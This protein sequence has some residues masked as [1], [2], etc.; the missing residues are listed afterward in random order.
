MDMVGASGLSQ[1][2][3][4]EGAE[5]LL[6]GLEEQFEGPEEISTK[7]SKKVLSRQGTS[8]ENAL[9]Q[10]GICVLGSEKSPEGLDRLTEMR[11]EVWPEQVGLE[12]VGRVFTFALSEMGS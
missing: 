3:I 10:E 6:L 2:E 5:K 8:R 4:Q 9:G 1:T 12:G 11:S 7:M